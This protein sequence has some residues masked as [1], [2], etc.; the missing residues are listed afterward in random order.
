MSFYVSIIH[1]LCPLWKEFCNLGVCEIGLLWKKRREEK[2][3]EWLQGGERGGVF[4]VCSFSF[5]PPLYLRTFCLL[6]RT[7]PANLPDVKWAIAWLIHP[8][9]AATV[10]L[11]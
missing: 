1:L 9:A 7:F 10:V 8:S 11:I 3:E 6:F 4:I 5:T 2:Q